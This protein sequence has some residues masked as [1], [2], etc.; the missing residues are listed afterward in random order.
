MDTIFKEFFYVMM[1]AIVGSVGTALVSHYIGK[2]AEPQKETSTLILRFLTPSNPL[3]GVLCSLI[4]IIVIN[5]IVSS[6]GAVLVITFDINLAPIKSA[7]NYIFFSS[8]GGASWGILHYLVWGAIA[9]LIYMW[10]Q[11]TA[12]LNLCI[13]A[14]SGFLSGAFV[15]PLASIGTSFLGEHVF[16][17]A[18]IYGLYDISLNSMFRLCIPGFLFCSGYGILMAYLLSGINPKHE[19]HFFYLNRYRIFLILLSLFIV[20]IILSKT[21]NDDT[22]LWQSLSYHNV[23]AVWGT[24]SIVCMIAL[25]LGCLAYEKGVKTFLL[26]FY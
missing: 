1:G 6:L 7:K 16:R 2:K 13:F 3:P 19:L 20:S 25:L 8:I 21:F 17:E 26:K 15:L 9:S 22:F 12:E 14:T 5:A 4:V 24:Y 23:L 10:V 18:S 11:K